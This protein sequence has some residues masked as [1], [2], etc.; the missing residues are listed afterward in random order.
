MKVRFV[1]VAGVL[2]FLSV[3]SSCHRHRHYHDVSIS[4]NDDEDIY[5]LSARFDDRK[6]RAVENYIH[7][8]TDAADIF[9]YGGH[10]NMDA[11]LILDDESKVYVKSR[12]GWLKIKFNKDENSEEAYER[13]KDMCEGIKEI[14][15][16]N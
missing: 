13:V 5:Q 14:L 3:F 10:G 4:I 11:T 9:K 16:K 8:Y 7:E 6:T 15:A 12:E 1:L 2:F